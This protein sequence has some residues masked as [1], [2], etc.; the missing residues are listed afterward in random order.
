[1]EAGVSGTRGSI[2]WG[3]LGCG[4][5]AGLFAEGLQAV[6][7]AELVAVGSRSAENAEAFGEKYGA[8][9]RHAS[10]E[11]LAADPDVDLVYV[12]TPHQ[13]HRE[14][15]LLCLNNGK[16]VV[17]EKPFAIN[18]AETAEM[19][20]TAREK[21]LFL[22][23]AM[24]TRFS[25]VMTA[26]RDLIASGAIGEVRMVSADFG[27]RA[28][29]PNPH[30]LFDP[31]YGG[32]ALMDVG[33]YVTSFASMILG[34]PSRVVSQLTIGEQG[35]DE[36][37]AFILGYESGALAILSAAIRTSSPQVATVMGTDGRIDIHSLWWRP[38]AFTLVNP[39]K[40][41]IH[42]EPERTGNGYNYEAIEAGRCFREGLTESPVMPLDETVAIIAT[43]D[44]IRRQAGIVFPME[45]YA[46][47]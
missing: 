15:T 21:N 33:V 30:R 6:P 34:T 46:S 41:P 31:A 20:A 44:E 40:D 18:S 7:D 9:R 47:C 45:T 2:R 3:I 5:I 19:I 24:W 12:A 17:C 23:E 32:G 1:M 29:P 39:G 43:L 11:A 25:P 14:S 36:Q 4:R 26:V 27:F 35:V 22:M 8:A 10:Y 37:A 38:A 13:L 42:F 28:T 16:G